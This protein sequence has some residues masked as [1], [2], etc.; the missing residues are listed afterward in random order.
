MNIASRFPQCNGGVGRML[1]RSTVH[2]AAQ[3]CE[4]TLDYNE[5]ENFIVPTPS[6]L[7]STTPTLM[8][9]PGG[10][11][12]C[13]WVKDLGELKKVYQERDQADKITIKHNERLHS[14]T[15]H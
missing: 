12:S 7:A 8:T 5:F 14:S 3:C 15:E 13:M 1:R 6:L 4:I 2:G 10:K 9:S 11:F